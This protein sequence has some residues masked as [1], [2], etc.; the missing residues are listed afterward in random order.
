MGEMK[1][2]DVLYGEFRWRLLTSVSALALMVGVYDTPEAYAADV[3]HPT[4][5]IELGGQ[6]DQINAGQSAW[7]LPTSTF[8]EALSPPL[9]HPPPTSVGNASPHIGFDADG[10]VSF[11]PSGSDWILSVSARY[12]RSSRGPKTTN[13][14]SYNYGKY[15]RPTTPAFV[16]TRALE[17]ERHLIID[18]QA[19]KDFGLGMKLAHSMVNFGVRIAQFNSRL[20]AHASSMHPTPIVT[21]DGGNGDFGKYPANGQSTGDADIRHSFTGLGPSIS[22]DASAPMLGSDQN[23][24][25]FDWNANGAILFGRQKTTLH[26]ITK[27][28]DHWYS[29]AGYVACGGA[30]GCTGMS[31]PTRVAHQQDTI[32]VRDRQIFVPNVGG[33]VGVSYHKGSA[34]V[35]LGYRADFFF[36]AIDG[37]ADSR[38][39]YDRGFFGP[40][41]NVSIGLGG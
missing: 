14:Q 17:T 7:S 23:G 12:G 19:G 18:F 37:G 21:G 41:A 9:D 25:S 31:L 3:D 1:N 13:D 39:T 22:W 4:I 8:P 20:E 32:R 24:F 29:H 6:F 36:G 15:G 2:F 26:V 10:K 16:D 34:K 35:S 5:W 28:I 30:V 38:K 40:F 27:E 11:A 33:L